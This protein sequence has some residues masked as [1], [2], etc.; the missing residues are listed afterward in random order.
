M[1]QYE[2]DWLGSRPIFYNTQTLKVSNNI[3]DVIDYKNIEL[4]PEGFNNYL[5]FGYS[6]FEQTPVKNVKF[7]R[8][9][10]VLRIYNDHSYEVEYLPDPVDS[11]FGKVTGEA[12]VLNLLQSKIAQWEN[13][14][15]GEIVLPLSGGFDSRL[16]ASMIANKSR[17][18]CFTYGISPEQHDSY[19][20]I[21]AKKI[22]DLLHLDWKQIELGGFNN[23]IDDWNALFG[24]STHTHGMY[25]IEFYT[26][27]L[28]AYTGGK[29][30]L[31][32]IFGDVWAGNIKK[33][34]IHSPLDVI[35]LGYTHGLNASS[36][37]SL[38]PHDTQLLQSFYDINR[39]KLQHEFYQIITTIRLK[40]ILISY[41]V[42]IP[43]SFGFSVFAPYLDMET[44]LSMLCLPA[45]RRRNRAWQSDY[46]K[47]C[48]L[49]VEN[50]HLN[51]SFENTLSYYGAYKVK[52]SP[53][54]Y[55]LYNKYIQKR[56]FYTMNSLYKNHVFAEFSGG[57]G[58]ASIYKSIFQKLMK[59]FHIRGILSRLGYKNPRERFLIRLFIYMTLKPFERLF[60]STIS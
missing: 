38:L 35:K 54:N 27:M 7:M 5:D 50:M 56:Y 55:Q 49:D 19:E 21:R 59:I 58:G 45:G 43:E 42:T 39:D 16:L 30:F 14:I 17:L 31:S 15:A 24:V 22:A 25:H 37:Y 34:A 9:A 33:Q 13:R 11:W 26:K 52:V 28:E 12:D 40:I 53:L 10:S 1:H 23:Y 60:R 44:A 32:G 6:V 36:K 20:V 48:G 18:R 2:Q 4:H 51:C 3:N 57:G 41:L 29:N 46:F 8:Y 47:K